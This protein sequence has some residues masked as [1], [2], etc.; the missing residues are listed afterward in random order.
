MP[1]YEYKCSGCEHQF[2][3]VEALKAPVKRKCPECNKNLLE[4]LLFPVMGRVKSIKNIGQLAEK[5]T[6]RAG[7]SLDNPDEHK[8][9][10]VKSKTKEL[11]AINRMTKQQQ[12]K[13]IEEG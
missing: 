13:Y 11:N 10:E 8:K 3:I 9:K 1:V 12:I 7:G 2:E 5:N 6:K 4:R